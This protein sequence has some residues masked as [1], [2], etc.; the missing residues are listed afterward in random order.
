MKSDL[1]TKALATEI[2]IQELV[3][4]WK[5]YCDRGGIVSRYA[6]MAFLGYWAHIGTITNVLRIDIKDPD[7]ALQDVIDA[8]HRAERGEPPLEPVHRIY[9]ENANAALQW[10]RRRIQTSRILRSPK[11]RRH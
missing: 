11:V 8:W 2:F 9:F 6:V 1:K 10:L 4:D 5:E 7:E 3:T